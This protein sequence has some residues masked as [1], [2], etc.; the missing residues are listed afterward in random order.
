M[1]MELQ[2]EQLE[3]AMDT[4]TALPELGQWS[5]A[6]CHGLATDVEQ[7]ETLSSLADVG[8]R[9]TNMVDGQFQAVPVNT[10]PG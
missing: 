9:T 10:F 4:L 8:L 5:R 1:V 6:L 3:E 7:K 2:L